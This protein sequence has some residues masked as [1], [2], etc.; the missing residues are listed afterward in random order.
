[1][2]LEV[3]VR[4]THPQLKKITL[5]DLQLIDDAWQVTQCEGELKNGEVVRVALPFSRLPRYGLR[6]SIIKYAKEDNVYAKGLGI[7]EAIN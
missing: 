2:Y 1:M 5:L 6:K 7:F 3:M 4:W